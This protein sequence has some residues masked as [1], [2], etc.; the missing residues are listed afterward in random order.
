MNHARGSARLAAIVSAGV[1]AAVI[2]AVLLI[3]PATQ[4]QLR[5]DDART[6]H[7]MKIQQQIDEYWH[8]HE[9]MPKDLATLAHEP[10]FDSPIHDPVTGQPYGFELVDSD[11]YRL[12]AEFSLDLGKLPRRYRRNVYST[13]DK[14]SHPAGR[15]C[16][17][18]DIV[19]PDE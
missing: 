4:R 3:D 8:R 10:G 12:C 11:S 19:K 17:T 16:F 2:T 18:R 15:F 7:L 13:Y 9:A 14:W 1:I 5:L 6:L